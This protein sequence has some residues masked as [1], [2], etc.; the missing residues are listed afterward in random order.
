VSP[1]ARILPQIIQPADSIYLSP[2]TTLT[3]KCVPCPGARRYM[4]EWHCRNCGCTSEWCGN[5]FIISATNE[6]F[7]LVRIMGYISDDLEIEW[8]IRAEWDDEHVSEWSETRIL[9]I[10]ATD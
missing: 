10:R 6:V 8:K 4:V 2:V 1:D 7:V 5:I 9:R 3:F